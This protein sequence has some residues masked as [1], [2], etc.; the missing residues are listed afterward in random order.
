MAE[1]ARKDD[2]SRMT[3]MPEFKEAVAQAAAKA[4]A[5]AIAALTK[6]GSLG[7][8]AFNEDATA[9]F[10]KMALAIAEISDQGTSRKRV[11]PEILAQR[12]RSHEQAVGLIIKA[13]E[14]VIEARAKN[15][16]AAEAKWLP[17]YRVISKIYFNERLIEPFRRLADKTVAN[18]EIVW[19]GMPNEALRP[20]NDV[21]KEIYEAFRASIGSTEK[22]ATA[23]NRPV[24]IT[25]QGLVV[26]G[27]PPKRREGFTEQLPDFKDD[28]SIAHDNNDPTAP[29][30]NVLGT[31]ASPARQNF[32]EKKTI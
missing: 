23:D 27:D 20:I 15:D 21:A 22:L 9:L 16:K 17:E 1:A 19:T 30:V 6:G 31:I 5:D 3:E 26:K 10:S 28:L 32:A 7:A 25:A 18:N 4:A 11:A 12:A 8:S 14:K 13:R 2:I 24:W 29:F